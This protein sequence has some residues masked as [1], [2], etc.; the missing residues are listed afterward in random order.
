LEKFRGNLENFGKFWK[1]LENFGKNWIFFEKLG[2][3]WKNL[4]KFGG[5]LTGHSFSFEQAPDYS[6]IMTL[7]QFR[8]TQNSSCNWRRI[9]W[10]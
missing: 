4:E 2:K 9:C 3:I 8:L 6:S 7:V 10:Y 5:N 1:I